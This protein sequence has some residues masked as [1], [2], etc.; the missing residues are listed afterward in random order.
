MYTT[1]HLSLLADLTLGSILIFLW[2]VRRH[3]RHALYW[4]IGQIMLGI[5]AGIWSLHTLGT[6]A[7]S[8]SAA[9]C[10][11]GIS[12]YIAGT[13]HF[14]AR[15]LRGFSNLAGWSMFFLLGSQLIVAGQRLAYTMAPL[16]IALAFAWCAWRL[17]RRSK[18]YRIVAALFALRALNN[19]VLAYASISGASNTNI[20]FLFLLA[21]ILKVATSLGLVHAVLHENDARIRSILNNLGHGFLIR[22][23][24]GIIRF[25]SQKL[26][27]FTANVS[28]DQLIGQHISILAPS[29]TAEQTSAWFQHVTAPD[30]PQPCI[31]ETLHRRQDGVEQ[32][33]EIISVPYEERGQMLVLSQIIDI[34]QRKEQEAALQ[35]VAMLDEST[36]LFNRSA[37][38][39]MLSALLASNA[40][41]Q[42]VALL[43]IDL[44][45][46]RR[47]NET[48][49]HSVGDQLLLL[50]AA[51]L[52]TLQG[53]HDILARFGGDEFVLVVPELEVANAQAQIEQFAQRILQALAQPF[54]LDPFRI[55]LKASIG[56]A[57]GPAHGLDAETL[58][59]AADTALHAAKD[60]G[61]N[62]YCLFEERMA[63][64]SRNALLIDEALQQAIVRD[65]FRL[66][67]QP[68]V[69]A[70]SRCLHKVEALIR[71]TTPAL[72]FVP[73]D[74]FIP[75]AEE[76]GQIV[77][78]GTWV[79]QEAARQAAAWAGQAGAPVCIS[80]NVS[81]AQLTDPNFISLVN[82]A[83]SHNG[84]AASTL[85]IEMTE[86][87]L[88]DEA[89]TVVRVIE[90]LHARG[91]STS[92]D[93]FGT[94]YSSL[95]YLTR[96]HLRTLKIDR[97]FVN[98]VEHDERKLSL[99]RAIIAMGHSL[100]MEI[101]AE[102]VET[103]EQA[104]I[105]ADLGCEYLQGYLFSR[106]VPAAE[107]PGISLRAS[108]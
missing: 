13:Q 8:L 53:S 103:E 72:G 56:I 97:S 81:A 49:G 38:R 23:A 11:I 2:V 79:L 60:A 107:L 85:E 20:E 17:L 71:W 1:I 6:T 28:A 18:P 80:I 65:E 64:S 84:I 95:S 19:T 74:H 102:G 47:I 93:D 92:L 12:A 26:T 45:H 50:V 25:A 90:A 99:V 27:E 101:V 42:R 108:S 52:K 51:R 61:R 89:D 66:F 68:I 43:L 4:G 37:L 82:D 73:P 35:R 5:A 96:F 78:I 104:T 69:E 30:T 48:L 46:F 40:N 88:I 94:G 39:Q 83:L 24:E 41:G 34:R 67:Y 32:P 9:C 77:D 100:G 10:V 36:D 21:F 16:C 87:V 57:F 91:L 54:P 76:S 55:A 62:R 59:S 70:R 86:R 63:A 15:P 58:L 98:G 31:D 3:D 75:I 105:L 7:L 106:P 22:D 33:L 14:C 29:R 44:D